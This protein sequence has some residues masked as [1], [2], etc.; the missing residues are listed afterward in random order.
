MIKLNKES[1]D[2]AYTVLK[3]AFPAAELR[4]KDKVYDLFIKEELTIYGLKHRDEIV[5]VLLCWYFEDFL[6]LENFAVKEKYRGKG[7]GSKILKEI[8]SIYNGLIILEV[9]KP[10]D[11]TSKKRVRFYEKNEFKL[12]RFGYD[13]PPFVPC[14]EDIPLLIMST[15]DHISE[16]EFSSIKK[17][18]FTK[19]YKKK[20]D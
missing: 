13:Q 10:Y 7:Y 20:L 19:V 2:E 9:E 5:A 14:I 8:K 6:F 12:N 11:D 18:I 16:E 17:Y 1:F 4:Q 3:D 15:P